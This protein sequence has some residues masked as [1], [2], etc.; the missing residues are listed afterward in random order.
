MDICSSDGMDIIQRGCFVDCCG[1]NKDLCLVCWKKQQVGECLSFDRAEHISS[2][3]SVFR[4]MVGV[5]AH[6]CLP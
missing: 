2:T 4:K 1:F 5:G 6:V 3:I